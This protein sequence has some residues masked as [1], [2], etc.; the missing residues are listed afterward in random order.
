MAYRK[1]TTTAASMQSYNEKMSRTGVKVKHLKAR[2]PK[3]NEVGRSK[4]SAYTASAG[5]NQGYDSETKQFTR[6]T[7]RSA[8]GRMAVEGSSRAGGNTWTFTEKDENGNTIRQSGRSGIASR[9]K[10]Y[11]DVRVGLGMVGG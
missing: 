6:G 5:N 7:S 1:N 10:R 11:Y 3:A 2:Q 9:R 4:N 8:T